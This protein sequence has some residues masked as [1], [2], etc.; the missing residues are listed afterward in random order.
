VRYGERVK[1]RKEREESIRN[2]HVR[3]EKGRGRAGRWVK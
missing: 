3:R 1:E 2:R